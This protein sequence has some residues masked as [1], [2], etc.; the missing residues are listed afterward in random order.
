MSSNSHIRTLLNPPSLQASHTKAKEE[1]NLRFL[2]IDDLE[3]LDFLV[4]EFRAR[5]DELNQKV[6]PCIQQHLC[7]ISNIGS[8]GIHFSKSCG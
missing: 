4:P 5:Q 7:F 2:T 8:S 6:R 3:D 1:I